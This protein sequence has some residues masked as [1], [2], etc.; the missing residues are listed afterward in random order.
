VI[1]DEY[2][3]IGGYVFP[4]RTT[5]RLMSMEITTTIDDVEIDA[6]D[7]AAFDLPDGVKALLEG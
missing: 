4:V 2:G 3:D 7:D 6:V 5:Q 1:N